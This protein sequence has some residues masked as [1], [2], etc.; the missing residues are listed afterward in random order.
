MRVF[1]SAAH[2][3][4]STPVVDEYQR[5]TVS[6]SFCTANT[7]LYLSIQL[8]GA[9]VPCARPGRQRTNTNQIFSSIDSNPKAKR[10]CRPLMGG[11]GL[12]FTVHIAASCRATTRSVHGGKGCYITTVVHSALSALPP[13]KGFDVAECCR[14][15]RASGYDPVKWVGVTK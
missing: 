12:A 6:V 1:I 5:C 4:L 2:S 9:C 11:E 10:P 13:A 14:S 3:L 7:R 15:Q 8:G